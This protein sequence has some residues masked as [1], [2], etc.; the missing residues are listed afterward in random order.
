MERLDDTVL[1]L[2]AE[3]L[4]EPDTEEDDRVNAVRWSVLAGL[5]AC[6]RRCAEWFSHWF[7]CQCDI[8]FHP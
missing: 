4:G 1:D 2:V 6:T 3:F 7:D 8:A 5:S